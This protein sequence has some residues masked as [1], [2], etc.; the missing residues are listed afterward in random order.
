MNFHIVILAGG[1]VAL[2]ALLR[3]IYM[4]HKGSVPHSTC[5][6]AAPINSAVIAHISATLEKI[7]WREVPKLD[8]L[9][10]RR[11]RWSRLWARPINSAV[12]G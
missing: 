6:L 10:H 2:G 7:G 9:S 8:L 3:I 5:L 12:I 1:Y 11:S 4:Q